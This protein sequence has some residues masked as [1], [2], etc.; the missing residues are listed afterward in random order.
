MRSL[1]VTLRSLQVAM[2]S[3]YAVYR[4][5]CDRNAQFTALNV[6]T[7]HSLQVTMHSLQVTLHCAVSA[8][9]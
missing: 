2:W 4:S 3:H 7:M 6:V 1:Q 5:Q 8:D 9:C